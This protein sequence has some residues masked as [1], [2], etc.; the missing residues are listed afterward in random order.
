MG[1]YVIMKLKEKKDLDVGFLEYTDKE[2]LHYHSTDWIN[3]I[4]RGG[5]VH[6]TDSFFQ[7]FLAIDTVTRQEMKATA[8]VMDDLFR[9]HLE[10]MITSDSD[11]FFCWT[12]ITG[13]ETLKLMK[14]YFMNSLNCG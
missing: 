2:Y 8:A 4:D 12:M 11:V 7:L 13:E 10:N 14:T 5:L 3:A 9:Q 1:S 6:I